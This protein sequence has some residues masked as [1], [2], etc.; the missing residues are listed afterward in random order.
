MAT[1]TP[2]VGRE[3]FPALGVF[4]VA[5]MVAAVIVSVIIAEVMGFGDGRW[6]VYGAQSAGLG[7]ILSLF[8][9][10]SRGVRH[11]G[12]ILRVLESAPASNQ[13]WDPWLD[14]GRDG[15]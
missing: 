4:V 13:L 14:S 11:S 3:V 8:V 2:R 6:Y 7:A 9:G 12:G 10:L 1:G 15:E 5:G